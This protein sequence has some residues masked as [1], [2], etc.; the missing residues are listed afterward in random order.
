VVDANTPGGRSHHHPTGIALL[1]I[2]VLLPHERVGK[3][4]K[5]APFACEALRETRELS[6]SVV[7][8]ACS[9]GSILFL[10]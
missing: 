7:A 10:S 2:S 4:A 5:T 1:P 8:V 6:V 9:D 3:V